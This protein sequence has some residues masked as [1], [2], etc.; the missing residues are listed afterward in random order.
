[1]LSSG[2]ILLRS[3]PMYFDSQDWWNE[4]GPFA[5]LHQ[6]MPLRMDFLLKTLR[7]HSPENAPTPEHLPHCLSGKTILDVGCGGGLV[8][9]ALAALG[10]KVVGIDTEPMALACAEKHKKP[11]MNI[12]YLCQDPMDW[13]CPEPVDAVVLFEVLEHVPQ[14]FS[15]LQRALGWLRPGGSILGSTINRTRLSALVGIGLAE[16]VLKW[17]PKGTHRWADFIQ[18][19]EISQG[20][21][22]G[23]ARHIHLQGCAYNP[24]TQWQYSSFNHIHYFFS[25]QK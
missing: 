5:L 16:H 22:H 8:S 6:W 25:A 24:L 13:I 15:L 20:L 21:T 18:P 17:V 4:R 23:R 14:P 1:M 7:A 12:T 10:A 3:P 11:P 9:E 19:E 2:V